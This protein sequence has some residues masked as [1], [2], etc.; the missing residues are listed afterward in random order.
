MK[1][2]KNIASSLI[3]SL[4]TMLLLS[5][6]ASAQAVGQCNDVTVLD[7]QT[8][9]QF[10]TVVT[11]DGACGR[12]GLVCISNAGESDS[13]SNRVYAAA[14]TAQATGANLRVR[15][16]GAARGCGALDLPMVFDFRVEVE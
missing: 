11:L 12:G 6:N 7:V 14:L 9:A 1:Q 13:V 16:D 2:T 4:S 8:G 3:L 5:T 15:W 10:G